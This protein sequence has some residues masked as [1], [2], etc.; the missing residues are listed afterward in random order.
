MM[1]RL[2]REV[3]R[4]LARVGPATGDMSAIVRAWPPAVGETIARNAWPARV[5][6]DG[7]LCVHAA[8]ATW[9]FELGRMAP[10][11]LEQLRRDLGERT[12]PSLR[13]VPGPIPEPE[14]DQAT[15]LRSRRPEVAPADRAEAAALAAA[16]A[17]DELREL[18]ARAAAASLARARSS[19]AF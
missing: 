1:E 10:A 14:P 12:P 13:V 5:A 6:R 7:T 15:E 11:I 8:S 9:A 16:I 2:D 17:D 19:R 4:E 18:V 3:R